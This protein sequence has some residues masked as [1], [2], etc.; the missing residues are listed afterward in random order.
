[1]LAAAAGVGGLHARGFVVVA[2]LSWATLRSLLPISALYLG[3]TAFALASLDKI[4]VPMYTVLKRL[5]PAFVLAANAAR[6]APPPHRAAAASVGLT[7]VGTLLAGLGDLGFNPQAYA[8]AATSCA[9][10]VGCPKHAGPKSHQDTIKCAPCPLCSLSKWQAAYL[11]SV[12]GV[13]S[14][15]S[16]WDLLLYNS[17]L[18]TPPL[19]LLC[20]VDG[21]AGSALATLPRRVA[22]E[23]GFAATFGAAIFLGVVLNL[24]TFLCTRLNSALTTTVVGG[25]KSVATTLLGF[26]LVGGAGASPECSLGQAVSRPGTRPEPAACALRARRQGHCAAGGGHRAESWG[27]YVVHGAGVPGKG[28]EASLQP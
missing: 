22:R 5:T 27:R 11:M 9:L 12:E 25:L 6:G 21:E 16:S 15:L 8:F 19:L 23:A 20:L 13:K 3:N 2:P 14:R 17:L 18:A 4:S 7:M 1:M 28:G 24:S 26:A 10:Q